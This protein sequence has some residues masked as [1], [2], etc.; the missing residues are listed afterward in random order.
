MVG[1]HILGQCQHDGAGPTV[2]GAVK[3]L[4][5]IFRDAGG[6]VDLRH[7]FRHRTEH[8]AE[9]DLLERLAL[10]LVARD[11]ADE[12][13]HRRGILERGVDADRGVGGTRAARHEADAGPARHLAVGLRHVGGAAFLPADDEPDLVAGV[14]QGIERGQIAFPGHAESGI[15]AVDLER[16]DQDLTAGAQ[17]AGSRHGG[18]LFN[19]Q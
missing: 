16:V 8:A 13:D 1:Q 19:W 11:L 4:A 3:G 7:P 6:V 10:H 15:D 2:D 5:D 18:T 9:I 14:V 12:Q 17:V